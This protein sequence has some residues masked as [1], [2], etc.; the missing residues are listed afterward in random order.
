MHIAQLYLISDTRT[1]HT[2]I[3]TYNTY[4]GMKINNIHTVSFRTQNLQTRFLWNNE[5]TNI[6]N[7]DNN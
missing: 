3:C 5:I 7:Y 2:T 6:F 4:A 1:L